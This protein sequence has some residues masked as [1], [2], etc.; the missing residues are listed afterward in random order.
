MKKGKF[1]IV[2]EPTAETVDMNLK[3]LAADCDIYPVQVYVPRSNQKMSMGFA[4][5]IAS[6]AQ[7]VFFGVM[8][9]FFSYGFL[10]LFFF[11]TVLYRTVRF[12]TVLFRSKFYIATVLSRA[13]FIPR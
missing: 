8:L 12:R 11:A 7:M 2:N 5:V 9:Y 1:L 13:S 3:V 4:C 10:P 6:I